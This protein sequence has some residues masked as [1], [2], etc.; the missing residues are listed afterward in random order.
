MCYVEYKVRIK[1]PNHDQSEVNSQISDNYT[2]NNN[3]RCLVITGCEFG[4]PNDI[5][6]NYKTSFKCH[7]T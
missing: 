6:E 2:N 4:G 3:N 7:N 5:F 1:W